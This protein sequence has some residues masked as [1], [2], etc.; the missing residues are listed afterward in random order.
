MLKAE[1]TDG[2]RISFGLTADNKLGRGATADVYSV[3]VDDRRLAAKIYKDDVV[4]DE[5]KILSMCKS[6]DPTLLPVYSFAW[7]IATILSN[8][9]IC[10]YLMSPFEKD[11]H[12]PLNYYFD[13][14][15]FYR[16]KSSE[17][18]SLSN[19]VEICRS[20]C[21]A[22]ADSHSVERHFVDLKPQNILV[23]W[24]TNSCVLLDCDGCS[25]KSDDGRRFPAG[26]I[27]TDY[28][29]PEATRDKLSPAQLGEDQDNYAL[30][31]ILF[32][33][34]NFG[35]HPFQG[36]SSDIEL[37][38][39]TNDEKAAAGLYPYGISVNS[40]IGPFAGSTHACMPHD[41]R[42]FFDRTFSGQAADRVTAREWALFFEKII[43]AKRLKPC[44]RHTTE[45]THIHFI[46]GTCPQCLRDSRQTLPKQPNRPVYPSPLPQ[47]APRP[48]QSNNGFM[49]I[50]CVVVL[51]IFFA[52]IGSDRSPRTNSS[53][54]RQ[55]TTA[56]Q[57]TVQPAVREAT[58]TVKNT[59]APNIT[60]DP[61]DLSNVPQEDLI[62]IDRWEIVPGQSGSDLIAFFSASQSITNITNPA[63]FIA[64][65]NCEPNVDE[66]R[67]VQQALNRLGFNVGVVDGIVGPRTINALFEFQRWRGIVASGELDAATLN[68]LDVKFASFDRSNYKFVSRGVF[69]PSSSG[70]RIVFSNIIVPSPVC[71]YVSGR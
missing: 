7:P 38:S 42:F 52:A 16:L 49:L 61:A 20:L 29:S 45:A 54:T 19:R 27:S 17:F 43:T 69:F 2:K 71:V 18:L 60:F 55:S 58:K 6:G 37:Q 15:L 65:I 56:T 68:L 23:N 9:Q 41:L 51:L 33:M 4:P 25:L 12:Y 10:G 5:I 34:F 46:D 1:F 8:D 32:Q 36:T 63:I 40:L 62:Y 39:A 47:P 13:S 14:T 70:P 26:H 64:N 11:D 66:I 21:C 22:I 24:R 67:R 50:A 28:I 30:A 48:S 31:V 59:P 35:Q 53:S 44:N 3:I 57:T